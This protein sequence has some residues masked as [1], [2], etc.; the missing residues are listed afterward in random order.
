MFHLLRVSPVFGGQFF[1]RIARRGAVGRRREL[2][3]PFRRAFL[4]RQ[5][6]R[7]SS[8]G[9]RSPDNNGWRWRRGFFHTGRSDGRHG[10]RGWYEAPLM[11][12]L[13]VFQLGDKVFGRRGVVHGE[14][15]V[16]DHHRGVPQRRGRQARRRL[17]RWIVVALKAAKGTISWC[18]FLK[19]CNKKI[20]IEKTSVNMQ[21]VRGGITHTS[22]LI[23]YSYR[24]IFGWRTANIVIFYT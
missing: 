10:A 16:D 24:P 14:F 1:R 6:Q 22:V 4:R 19:S 11:L 20:K 17:G 23:F 3:V 9:R 8:G 13:P 21:G 15:A 5:V 18:G 7:R 2:V 12:L